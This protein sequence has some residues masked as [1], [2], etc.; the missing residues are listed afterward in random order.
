MKTIDI[1]YFSG[2]GNTYLVAKEMAKAFGERGSQC[3]LQRMEA[4]DPAKADLTHTIGL[5]FPIAAFT[6]YPLVWEFVDRMPQAKG[7]PVFA[8][9]TMA[10]LSLCALGPLKRILVK[11]GYAPI[12]AKQFKM[13]SNL[14]IKKYN[15]KRTEKQVQ[16]AM[17]QARKF[18]GQVVDGR[19]KWI[20]FPLVPNLLSPLFMSKQ[21]WRNTPGY[22]KLDADKCTRC[23][24]C[25]ELCPVGAIQMNPDVRVT[26]KCQFCMRCVSYCPQQ[27]LYYSKNKYQRYQPVDI[28]EMLSV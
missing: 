24:Q 20:K 1:Y 4:S 9:A 10:G 28:K 5:G 26:G 18:A 17:A 27:A 3:R 7:T 15:T 21:V 6:T 16:K 19:S 22:V 13:P 12:A 14:W 23:A 25:L 11:K 2:T 8:F